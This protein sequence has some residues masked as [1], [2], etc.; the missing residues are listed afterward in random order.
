MTKAEK[1]IYNVRRYSIA[2]YTSVVYFYKSCS[3]AKLAAENVIKHEMIDNNGTRY[4]VICGNSYQFI[5]GY[6]YP[7]DDKWYLRVHTIWR[8]TDY[9][10]TEEEVD[11]LYL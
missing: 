10:L 4:R 8:Y 3:D 6:C 11:E 1:R 7:K 5:C 2:S 9:E